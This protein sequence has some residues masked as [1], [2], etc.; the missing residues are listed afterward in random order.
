MDSLAVSLVHKAIDFTTSPSI[1]GISVAKPSIAIDSTENFKE[2]TTG[3][4]PLDAR[5]RK[6]ILVLD[7]H[8]IERC[9]YEPGA[10]QALLDEEAYVL[11]FPVRMQGDI[12]PALQ[13][14]LDMGQARPGVILVQSPY[15]PDMYEEASLAVH[16]FAL[17]KHMYFSTLCMYLGAKDR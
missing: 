1:T 6:A 7:Q 12:S 5:H 2:M 14:V 17:A 13:N 4:F 15:D 3:S 16:R 8:D 10:A 11:S 9:G